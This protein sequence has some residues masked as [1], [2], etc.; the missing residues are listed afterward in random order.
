MN[1]LAALLWL[2]AAA[3]LC[4]PARADDTS[5]PSLPALLQK[6]MAAL[7][8]A[9]ALA[10]PIKPQRT[11]GTIEQGG[12][13][14]TIVT[15]TQGL[16]KTWQETKLGIFDDTSGSDGQT[17]WMRDT[18][19][20]VRQ[21]SSEETKSA[22]LDQYVGTYSYLFPD[23]LPG[24]V[25]LRSKTEPR[26]GDYILDVTPDGGRP[27]ALYLDPRTYLVVKETKDIG[28][29][30]ATIT[31]QNFKPLGGI[32]TATE[33]R[34]QYSDKKYAQVTKTNTVEDASDVVDTL[35]APP[36][37]PP[38]Y[39]WIKPGATSAELPIETSDHRVTLYAGL[40]G[41]PA[42]LILDSGDSSLYLELRAADILKLKHQGRLPVNGYGGVA[43]G[44]PFVLDTFELP[45]G[46]AFAGLT[47]VATDTNRLN[48]IVP[49]IAP[50]GS[51]GYDLLSRLV[52]RVDIAG[53]TLTVSDPQTWKPAPKDGLALPLELDNNV[54]SVLAQVD[55]LPPARFLI[56]TGDPGTVT[57]YAPYVKDHN[58]LD[59]Y[60]KALKTAGAGVGGSFEAKKARVQSLTLG[61]IKMTDVPATLSLDSKGGG[62]TSL[63]GAIGMEVLERYAFTFDYPGRRV[64]F[65]P[66]PDAARPFDTRTFGITIVELP[67]DFIKTKTH[68]L[69]TGVNHNASA[70]KNGLDV[71]MEVLQI[72][73]KPVHDLGLAEVRRL[74]SPDG[75]KDTHE[76]VARG[77]SRLSATYKATMFDPLP[78]H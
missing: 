50:V 26:S 23:R 54:P 22:R 10:V 62:D 39:E 14:G 21:Q 16:S 4:A 28:G 43:D 46:V 7:G 51:I 33:A 58:L 59:K 41:Q 35:F 48:A 68:F 13:Q 27:A 38:N 18:S 32:L 53:A 2:A 66:N 77:I 40:N 72:D 42:F 44:F 9:Q 25:A 73:G 55:G 8:G 34:Q 29:Q 36:P 47:G 11:T 71:G 31:F 56:D 20:A 19:G 12:L 74:L 60:P 1:R 63:A 3:V 67:D 64:F 15:V 6:H 52:T 57:L 75:G 45:G 30:T 76:I 5:A 61:G 70:Y 37:S 49:V 24:K 17:F 65:A 78:P 69:I